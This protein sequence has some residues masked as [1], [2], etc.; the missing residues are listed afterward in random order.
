MKRRPTVLVLVGVTVFLIGASLVMVSLR[1]KPALASGSAR[2]P[3]PAAAAGTPRAAAAHVPSEVSIPP[4]DQA[5]AVSPATVAAGVGAYLGPGD[6]V[7]VYA[8][9]TKL[10]Q[11]VQGAPIPLPVPCTLLVAADVPVID[12][13]AQVPTYKGHE[14]STGRNLPSAMTVLLA[15][16]TAQAPSIVFAAVNE[17]VYLTEVPDASAPAPAGTCTGTGPAGSAG[18][19][20]EGVVQ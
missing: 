4:G 9:I 6:V 18:S 19:F 10:S 1:G 2:A 14:N 15:A 12:V 20:A 11:T 7:D 3:A 5:V 17:Q 13:S 16:T 8:S